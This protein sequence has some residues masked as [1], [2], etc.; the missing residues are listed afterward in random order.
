MLAPTVKMP[1][2]AA[3]RVFFVTLTILTAISVLLWLQI[4]GWRLA[5]DQK[6]SWIILTVACLPAVQGLKLQQLTLLVAA[7]IAGCIAA[8]SH[9]RLIVGGVLL[10]LATIKPQL[11]FL[12]VIWLCIWVSGNWRERGRVLRGFGITMFLLIGAGEILLPGWIQEFREAMASY[13]RYTGGGGISIIDV[14]FTPIWGRVI[15]A[16]LVGILLVLL[17]RM[18]RGS[19]GTPEFIYSISLTLATTL[20]VIPMFAPYNQ[21]LLLAP[22][23]LLFRSLDGSLREPGLTRFFIAI[24]KLSLLWPFLSAALL[25]MAVPFLPLLVIEKGAGLPFYSTLAIPI[26]VYATLLIGKA[27]LISTKE[28]SFLESPVLQ[29]NAAAE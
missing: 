7:L 27:K 21:I 1:F 29:P 4:L 19:P 9:R 24:T 10:A 28:Y 23:M 12:L 13:Y 3:Q 17:W 6:V 15:A 25:V 8:I 20:L 16:G 2:W 11:V 18:R 14:I 26:T 22:V 5:F